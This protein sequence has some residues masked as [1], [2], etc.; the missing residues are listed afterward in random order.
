[1][2]N[3]KIWFLKIV[4]KRSYLFLQMNTSNIII[5]NI[6]TQLLSPFN[7]KHSDAVSQIADFFKV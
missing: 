5:K 1:M 7:K 3:E 4:K 2:H 6:N